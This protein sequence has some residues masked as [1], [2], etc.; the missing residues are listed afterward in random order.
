MLAQ[1]AITEDAITQGATLA[2]ILAGFAFVGSTSATNRST[3][4]VYFTAGMFMLVSLWAGLMG[5]M[6]ENPTGQDV[7]ANVFFFA[8]GIGSVLFVLATVGHIAG[9]QGRRTAAWCLTL[10]LVVSITGIILAVIARRG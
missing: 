8:L 4:V 9:L 5:L 6:S 7:L 10:A 1:I 2:S 3:V